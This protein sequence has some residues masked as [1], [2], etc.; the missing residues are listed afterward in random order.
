[1]RRQTGKPSGKRAASV[2]GRHDALYLIDCKNGKKVASFF[3]M[4]HFSARRSRMAPFAPRG[5]GKREEDTGAGT[6]LPASSPGVL[7]RAV[8]RRRGLGMAYPV[9]AGAGNAGRREAKQKG[10]NGKT[11]R[12]GGKCR[13]CGKRGKPGT[14]KRRR[15]KPLRRAVFRYLSGLPCCRRAATPQAAPRTAAPHP[16]SSSASACSFPRHSQQKQACPPV[17]GHAMPACICRNSVLPSASPDG[18]G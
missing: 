11:R 4:H 15:R 6:A 18:R 12:R 2:S 14:S 5:G 1:M 10:R 8:A 17:A 13:K 3:E 9:A 16:I 7:S